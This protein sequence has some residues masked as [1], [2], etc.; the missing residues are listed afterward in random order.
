MNVSLIGKKLQMIDENTNHEKYRDELLSNPE[1]K[2]NYLLSREKTKFEMMLE[3]LRVQVIEEKS[4]KSIL[5]QI[6]KISNRISQVY[7]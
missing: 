1:Y 3:T 2:A 5:G 6:T 4:R 7:L